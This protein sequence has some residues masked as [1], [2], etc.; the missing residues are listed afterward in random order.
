[1]HDRLAPAATGPGAA[2][3]PGAGTPYFSPMT[4]RPHFFGYGSLVNRTTHDF[5]EA[6]PARAR[7]WR[8]VWSL[9]GQRQH[10]FLSVVRDP[11]TEID[12]LVA[13]VPNGDWQALDAREAGYDRLP[14]DADVEHRLDGPVQIAI[15]AVRPGAWPAKAHMPIPMSYLDVV[16]QGFL[17]EFGEAGAED[18]FDTTDNWQVGLLD[19]RAA[20]VYPRH[21]SL[22]AE[23]RGFVDAAVARRSFRIV[24]G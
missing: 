22:S 19:D 21:R 11:A 10:A 5:V 9:T 20:P 6:H 8:R 18:F 1:M 23:E 3:A 4:P 13:H 12:G 7:G 14:A 2:V 24:A 17:R 16:V 15:Y